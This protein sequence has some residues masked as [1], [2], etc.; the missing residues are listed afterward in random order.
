ME[1][2][3]Y[4]IPAF[5]HFPGDKDFADEITA[6]RTMKELVEV[7]NRHSG[8]RKNGNNQYYIEE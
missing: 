5:N 2:K 7:L 3:Q 1:A 8:I 6:S 4:F